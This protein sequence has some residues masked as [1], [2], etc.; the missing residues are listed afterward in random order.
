ML[1]SFCCLILVF[2]YIFPMNLILIPFST[3]IL[4]ALWGGYKVFSHGEKNY[5]LKV[6]HSL[7]IIILLILG[8]AA[9]STV[10]MLLNNTNDKE[11]LLYPSVFS[12]EIII[13]GPK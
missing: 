10:T 2:I 1:A 11:Y 6:S 7:Y 13:S 8:I 3:R 9:I 12:G 4:L 5:F